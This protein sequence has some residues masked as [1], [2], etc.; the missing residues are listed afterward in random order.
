MTDARLR[1]LERAFRASGADEDHAR[2]IE[3]RLRLDLLPRRRV[4]LAARI[5]SAP[6]RIAL[7]ES[8]S[9]DPSTEITALLEASLFDWEDAFARF[10]DDEELRLRVILAVAGTYRQVP[11]GPRRVDHHDATSRASLAAAEAFLVAPSAP[12]R[13]V[14]TEAFWRLFEGDVD[15]EGDVSCTPDCCWS[16]RTATLWVSSL[17]TFYSGTAAVTGLADRG[18]EDG[19]DE[20]GWRD[21]PMPSTAELD[22]LVRNTTTEVATFALAIRFAVEREVIPWATGDRDPVAERVA[23]GPPSGAI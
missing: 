19:T 13:A 23:A 12:R 2:L 16:A 20:I 21:R 17:A 15:W 22:E 14:A 8:V 9:L 4:A 7:G 10:D 5:G 6:A 18:H 3:H 11:S 1:E